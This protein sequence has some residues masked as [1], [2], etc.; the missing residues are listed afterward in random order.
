[1]SCTIRRSNK[2]AD[3]ALY[4]TPVVAILQS[5]LQR[6]RTRLVIEEDEKASELASI[7]RVS[8]RLGKY[9]RKFFPSISVSCYTR[10]WG[11][12][13]HYGDSHN[14]WKIM[15]IKQAWI[16]FGFWTRTNV[17]FFFP[18]FIFLNFREE[19][20]WNINWKTLISINVSMIIL[21]YKF[22]IE[23]RDTRKLK[24]SIIER[25]LIRS[26]QFE[27]LCLYSV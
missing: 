13:D 14:E 10:I 18:F 24:F 7:C 15:E 3:M 6:L 27:T 17:F 9:V 1:M 2:T 12:F 5:W 21:K 26:F 16:L 19:V 8:A 25:S 11:R 22:R 23:C 4:T 20:N